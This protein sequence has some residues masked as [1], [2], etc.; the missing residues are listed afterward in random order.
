M[1]LFRHLSKAASGRTQ[2]YRDLLKPALDLIFESYA[3]PLT[4]AKLARAC[5]MSKMTFYRRFQ[6]VYHKNPKQFLNDVRMGRVLD[7]L[8][9]T[10]QKISTV[11]LEAGFFN[12]SNFSR[13]FRKKFGQSPLELRKSPR[14][15]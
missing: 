3:E 5:S 15:P 7:K 1:G 2:Q 8:T 12:L 14:H 13:I 11:A 9:V 6:A 4:A 10:D